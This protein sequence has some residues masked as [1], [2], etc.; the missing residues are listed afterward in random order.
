MHGDGFEAPVRRGLIGHGCSVCCCDG[1]RIIGARVL[2]SLERMV[3][4][5]WGCR[6]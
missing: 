6:A 5:L 4:C 1:R 2:L 3:C